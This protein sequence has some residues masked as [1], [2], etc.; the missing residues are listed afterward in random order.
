MRP[1]LY[2]FTLFLILSST[3]SLLAQST[4]G[5]GNVNLD[6]QI[7]ETFLPGNPESVEVAS[8]R[9]FGTELVV[10]SYQSNWRGLY[11]LGVAYDISTF[12]TDGTFIE[13]SDGDAAFVQTPT[14]LRNNRLVFQRIG[15]P[16]RYQHRLIK[17]DTKPNGLY[18]GIGL[19]PAFDVSGRQV[20]RQ[21]GDAVNDRLSDYRRF[22]VDLEVSF[23]AR[24][25]P[26]GSGGYWKIESGSRIQLLSPADNFRQWQIFVRLGGF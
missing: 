4:S 9:N 17:G 5:G 11:V 14:A 19:I 13:N 6:F 16:I 2:S 26:G 10:T 22:N 20:Y 18:A 25:I 1:L 15:I 7:G 3:P 23:L 21:N 12:F 24:N 8:G